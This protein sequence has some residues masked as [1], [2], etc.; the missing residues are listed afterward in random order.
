MKFARFMQSTGMIKTAPSS[1][2][3]YFFPEVHSLSGS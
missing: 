2:Q 1:W 3:D